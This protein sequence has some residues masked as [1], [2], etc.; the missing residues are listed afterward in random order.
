[1]IQ[2]KKAFDE[3]IIE[4]NLHCNPET[5]DLLTKKYLSKIKIDEKYKILSNFI[6]NRV[7]LLK[8]DIKVYIHDILIQEFA[9]VDESL[10]RK[11][12]YIGSIIGFLF[13][14]YIWIILENDNELIDK[15][16][17][18]FIAGIFG[19]F[20]YGL[21]DV[22]CDNGLV[23]DQNIYLS[24]E[25]INKY[26]NKILNVFGANTKYLNLNAYLK[27]VLHRAEYAEKRLFFKE[28]PYELGKIYQSGYKA[29]H[30]FFPIGAFLLKASY[31]NKKIIDVYFKIY[32]NLAAVIQVLDDIGDIEEDL[33]NGHYS[34]PTLLFKKTNSKIATN[35]LTTKEIVSNTELFNTIIT[36]LLVILDDCEELIEVHCEVNYPFPYITQAIKARLLILLQE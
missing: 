1:M 19:T 11:D 30:L 21:L 32:L 28:S 20:G 25:L 36:E 5:I 35:K 9:T 23:A 10:S 17:D 24:L 13:I 3:I 2:A 12:S 4:T 18:L 33:Q 6:D 29:A 14:Y 34:Y 27:S 7:E 26:E 31:P 8:E 16:D 15:F 22:Y